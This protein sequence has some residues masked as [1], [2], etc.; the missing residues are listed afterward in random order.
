MRGKRPNGSNNSDE[1]KDVK[2]QEDPFYGGET[3]SKYCVDEQR[4]ENESD[5]YQA[6]M[7][8]LR[9][10]AGTVEYYKALDFRAG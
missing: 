2:Q 1:A 8:S 3:L 5:C 7:P 6:P 4:Y 9:R 10:V